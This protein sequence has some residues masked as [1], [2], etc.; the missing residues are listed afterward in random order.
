[1]R[2]YPL[3]I[4]ISLELMRS[5]HEAAGSRA[6]NTERETDLNCEKSATETDDQDCKLLTKK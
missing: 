1:M 5:P 2:M 6:G 3:C 4:H